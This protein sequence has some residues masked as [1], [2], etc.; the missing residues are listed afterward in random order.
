MRHQS[1]VTQCW[2]RIWRCLP[3]QL[4][5]SWPSQISGACH[6]CSAVATLPLHPFDSQLASGVSRH[7]NTN[8]NTRHMQAHTCRRGM[9]SVLILVVGAR[10]RASL[11]TWILKAGLRFG[12]ML[13]GP[14]TTCPTFCCSDALPRDFLVRLFSELRSP[15]NSLLCMVATTETSHKTQVMFPTPSEHAF[16]LCGAGKLA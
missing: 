5:S 1:C 9:T 13:C 7:C 3:K 15:V 14:C 10:C 12:S 4:L 11:Q 8:T 2:K 16:V 6:R